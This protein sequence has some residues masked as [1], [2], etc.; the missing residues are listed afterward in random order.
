MKFGQQTQSGGKLSEDE[1]A[2]KKFKVQ[3]DQKLKN[4]KN[5]Q[6]ISPE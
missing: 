3:Y 2:Y 4:S 5:G 6:N 1:K